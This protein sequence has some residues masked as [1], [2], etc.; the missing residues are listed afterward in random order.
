[1]SKFSN[2]WIFYY[3]KKQKADRIRRGDTLKS[4]FKKKEFTE[5][6]GIHTRMV[7][8]DDYDVVGEGSIKDVSY[9]K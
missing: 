1:M 2:I 3:S 7:K 9:S 6:A 8:Y 5:A 4:F